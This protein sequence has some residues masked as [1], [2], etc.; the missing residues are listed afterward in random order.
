MSPL[1]AQKRISVPVRPATG[2]TRARMLFFA[3]MSGGLLALFVGFILLIVFVGIYAGLIWP[4][5]FWDLASL[6][7][8]KYGNWT[9]TMVLSVFAGGAF[10]G[11]LGFSGNPHRAKQAAVP[12]VLT[13]SRR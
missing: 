4:L 13:R 1:V 11:Y 2:I 6:G 7:L 5:T 10:A 9:G 8:E 12:Q 3:S